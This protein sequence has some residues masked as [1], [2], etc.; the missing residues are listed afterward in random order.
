MQH[1]LMDDKIELTRKRIYNY[2]LYGLDDSFIEEKLNSIFADLDCTAKLNFS[3]GFILRNTE[4]PSEFRYYYAADNNPVFTTPVTMSNHHDLEFIKDR[5][6]KESIFESAIQQR[7]NTKWI[8]FALTNVT[9]FVYLM[10]SSP[11]G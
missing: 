11:L 5:I 3:F 8:F 2:R 1:F 9:F 6:D 4:D 7:S 10:P